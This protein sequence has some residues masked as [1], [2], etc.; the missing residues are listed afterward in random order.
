MSSF[1][2]ESAR[3]HELQHYLLSPQVLNRIPVLE[4]II[5]KKPSQK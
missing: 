2:P 1:N 4:K 3:A 5:Q